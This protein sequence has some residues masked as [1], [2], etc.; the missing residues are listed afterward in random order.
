[1]SKHFI[2][3]IGGPGL[4]KGCDRAHDQTWLNYLVPMQIAAMK[5]YYKTQSTE[6]VHWFVFEPPYKNRWTDD[7]VIT[8][9]EKKQ[10]D[11]KELHSLR[12]A[13][14]DKILLKGAGSYLE[15]IKQIA[16]SNGIRYHGLNH[17]KDFWTEIGKFPDGSIS[18]VWYSGHAAGSGLFLS[19]AHN[20]AC[21]PIVGSVDHYIKV[22]DIP[23]N[24]TLAKKFD[25]TTKAPSKFYGC[26][27]KGFAKAWHDTFGVP[28]E[29]ATNKID[30]GV[31]DRASGIPNLLDRLEKTPTSEGDPKWVGF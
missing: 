10:D 1:M 7:S 12:K 5:G 30:F 24:K 29:G 16:K 17:R 31:I 14:T 22:S 26:Y 25:K 28:T 20:A 11:G 3:L 19:L 23:T 8:K 4:F 2:I 6:T 13:A 9:A 27:T 21:G 18:R 15:R